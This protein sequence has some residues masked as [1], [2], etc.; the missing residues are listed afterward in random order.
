MSR[1]VR[2]ELYDYARGILPGA[3]EAVVRTHLEQ[4]EECSGDLQAIRDSLLLLSRAD[5]LPSESRD[6][7]FWS[8]LLDRV[9]HDLQSDALPV[10]M[11]RRLLDATVTV[12]FPGRRILAFAGT[13]AVAIA[14]LLAIM[15]WPHDSTE[16]PALKRSNVVQQASDED[17]ALVATRRMNDY[18]RKSKVLLVGLAN[19]KDRE[20][21]AANFSQEREQSRLLVREAREIRQYP[22]DRRSD[23]LVGDVQ[24]IL[25]GLANMDT[26]KEVPDVEILRTGIRREN[27]L[28]RVRMAENSTTT[29]SME[30]TYQ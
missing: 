6:D 4:C 16:P 15:L 12:D 13:G 14:A 5:H 25:I 18:F 2:A 1:H 8:G 26:K 30:G 22:L 27:L 9:E 17:P 10:P 3:E 28:F 11:W 23:R 20:E 21:E 24:K 7:A 19:M 29:R